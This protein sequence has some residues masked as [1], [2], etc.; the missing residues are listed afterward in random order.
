MTSLEDPLAYTV[1]VLSSSLRCSLQLLM[2]QSPDP[3]C[4]ASVDT[5]QCVHNAF[6][7][8]SLFSHLSDTGKL[9]SV[10]VL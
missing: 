6:A 2:A 9:V 8:I 5:V 4:A 7:F 1:H 10:S 3:L